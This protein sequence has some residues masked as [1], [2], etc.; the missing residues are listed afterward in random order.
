MA[1]KESRHKKIGLALGGGG[2]R[3][4]AHIGIIKVFE[5]F[6]IPIDFIA[7]T[8]MGAVVGGWYAA[9]KDI[10][11]VEN[12]F[13]NLKS[14]DVLP[15]HKILRQHDGVIFREDAMVSSMEKELANRSVQ[16]CSIPFHAVATNIKNGDAVVLKDGSLVAAI[17]ASSAVPIVFQPVRVDDKLLIDGGFSNPVPADVVRAMGA[18]VVVA[19]DVSSQWIDFSS[20]KIGLK[21][22]YEIVS[23]LELAVEYELSKVP[24]KSADVILRPPVTQFGWMHF[25][26]AHAIIDAG[27]DE[28]R[29]KLKD[30]R[31]A[32]NLTEPPKTFADQVFGFLF[33]GK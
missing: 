12:I 24:L 28:A 15:M 20:T 6:G 32:A 10:R 23:N 14:H 3:G 21:N 25:E 13:L 19:V 2:A 31:K 7:G 17:K 5:A 1:A 18:D 26:E 30:L 8:S 27:V 22:F 33:D 16:D 11:T 9:T 29:L 4:L